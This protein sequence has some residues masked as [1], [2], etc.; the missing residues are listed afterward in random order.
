VR[1]EVVSVLSVGGHETVE[2]NSGD[3]GLLLFENGAPE[4]VITAVVMPDKDGLEIIGELRRRAFDGPI[5]ALSNGGAIRQAL[6][7]RLARMMGAD[8]SLAEP[9]SASD[10]IEAVDRVQGGRKRS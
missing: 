3:E 10:L 4:L 5:I 1:R 7:L 8:E 2:A 9:F 6:N